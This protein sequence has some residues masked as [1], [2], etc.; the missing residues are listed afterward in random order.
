M[1]SLL[2]FRLLVAISFH[3]RLYQLF[4]EYKKAHDSA[5]KEVLYRILIEF[6]VTMAL[7]TLIKMC[8]N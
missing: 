1:N 4:I 3:L 7:V 6:G 2:F 5:R 8:L